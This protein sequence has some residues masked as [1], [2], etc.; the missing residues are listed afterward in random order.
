M[1]AG[2]E[3]MWLF[4][5]GLCYCNEHTTDGVIPAEAVSTLTNVK[6][7]TKAV[8]AL[9]KVGLWEKNG[10][11]FTVLRYLDFQRSAEQIKE[12]QA[13]ASLAGKRSA[14][15]RSVQPKANKPFNQTLN[16]P[17]T[18]GSTEEEEEREEEKAKNKSS[19]RTQLPADFRPNETGT[20]LCRELSLDLPSEL[21][22]FSDHHKAKGSVMLDWQAAW[23]TW[24]QRSKDFSAT[25]G[26]RPV[27]GH[28]P[29]KNPSEE[30]YLD[31]AI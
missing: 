29:Y 27:N 6:Q 10:D 11:D 4:V 14:V 7:L 30:A 3:A 24:I 13:K 21:S 17:L 31:T 23:R 16:A 2:P 5:A 19:R 8:D 28:Q 15:Q 18:N 20:R 12:Q 25:G 1:K 26:N 22:K 9:L